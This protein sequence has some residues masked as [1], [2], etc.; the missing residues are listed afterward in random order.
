M[1]GPGRPAM[2]PEI[3]SVRELTEEDLAN[4]KPA[5]ANALKKLRDSHHRIAHLYALGLRP[6]EIAEITGYSLPRLSTL[7]A[8]PQMQD[9]IEVYRKDVMMERQEGVDDHFTQL[10]RARNLA[11]GRLVD[12]LEDD[13]AEFSPGQL[14]AIA[15]DGSDRT[16]YPK[17]TMALNVNMDFAARL[18]AAVK[19]SQQ[20][21]TIEGEVLAIPR[22]PTLAQTASPGGGEGE[23]ASDR[24]SATPELA[25]PLLRRRA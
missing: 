25:P 2:K 12:R 13:D 21:K 6:G 17:R 5:P 24:P 8:A 15:A 18:D 10:V 16:G 3:I 7:R 23:Q 9:L 11:L 19:R 20:V 14:L 22:P 1:F 4:F